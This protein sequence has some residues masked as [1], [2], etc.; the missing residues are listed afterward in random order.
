MERSWNTRLSISRESRHTAGI[1]KQPH[2]NFPIMRLKPGR[3]HVGFSMKL[4]QGNY[5]CQLVKLWRIQELIS[6][7]GFTWHR[8]TVKQASTCVNTG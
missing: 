1:T 5:L 3:E 8:V 6:P 7:Y 2:W 4:K